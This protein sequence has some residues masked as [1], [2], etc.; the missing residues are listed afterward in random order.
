MQLFLFIAVVI[1]IVF[2]S[3]HFQN[4]DLTVTIKFIT[5]TF[6]Q[7]SIALILAVPF[8]I[9]MLAGTFIFVPP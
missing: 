2:G 5:W 7:K 1:M 8:A 3:I 4:Q 6:E 9:G